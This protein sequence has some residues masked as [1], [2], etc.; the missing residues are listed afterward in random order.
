MTLTGK[1]SVAIA[2]LAVGG[3]HGSMAE[4]AERAGINTR[5][6]M[7]TLN[8]YW[9][10]RDLKYPKE[11]TDAIRVNAAGTVRAVNKLLY[12]ASLD[13]I[14][15]DAVTSGWRPVAINDATAN[16]ASHSNHLTAEAVDIADGNR[17][18]ALWCF[19]NPDKLEE[20]GLW[21]E[22]FRWTPTWV[23]LQVVPPKSG[24]RI[25]IPSTKPPTAPPLEGQT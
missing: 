4:F 19:N 10:E 9:A 14:I 15:R 23:H 5:L 22:D 21:A 18:F 2:R 13:D 11:C 12:L 25:Y 17:V 6:K 1:P 24:K 16:A 8:Q 3:I 7:I 20:C